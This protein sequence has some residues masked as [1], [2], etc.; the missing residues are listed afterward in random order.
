MTTAKKALRPYRCSRTSLE[1]AQ[2]QWIFHIATGPPVAFVLLE[3]KARESRTAKGDRREGNRRFQRITGRRPTSRWRPL[4]RDTV[5]RR[6]SARDTPHR[7]SGCSNCPSWHDRAGPKAHHTTSQEGCDLKE[8]RRSQTW[9]CLKKC[10]LVA[11]CEQYG[12]PLVGFRERFNRQWPWPDPR[13]GTDC[14]S[15]RAL[16]VQVARGRSAIS[17]HV[18]QRADIRSVYGTR[19]SASSCRSMKGQMSNGGCSRPLDRKQRVEA[20]LSTLR[21]GRAQLRMASRH[22]E[23]ART[24]LAGHSRV[25]KRADEPWCPR[26]GSVCG[27]E[28]TRASNEAR[29]RLTA[30]RGAGKAP[31]PSSLVPAR[32][33]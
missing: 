24:G 15:R 31:R 8:W 27:T 33:A 17:G 18:R 28:W 13:I 4:R 1:R 30:K 16:K 19:A 29:P 14:L 26:W 25:S 12:D 5:G 2:S 21:A 20:P 22:R 32:P 7:S 11:L 23:P 9:T 10:E 6:R 3:P